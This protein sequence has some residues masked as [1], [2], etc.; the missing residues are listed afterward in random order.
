MTRSAPAEV[1]L[2]LPMRWSCRFELVEML[3]KLVLIAVLAAIAEESTTYLN[4]AEVVSIGALYIFARTSS[5]SPRPR[6]TG[7]KPS[8]C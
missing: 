5:P 2:G 6:S 8:P 7:S 1:A 4:L 3:R